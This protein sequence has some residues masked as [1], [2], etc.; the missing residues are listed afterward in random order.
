MHHYGRKNSKQLWRKEDKGS[1]HWVCVSPYDHVH[2]L[3]PPPPL[4]DTYKFYHH[5]LPDDGVLTL[6]ELHG[7]VRDIWLA[8]FDDQLEAEQTSRR[9]GRP[10]SATQM[11]M[12]EIKLRDTDEYR[13]G[14][15]AYFAP[16]VVLS[17][18]ISPR[19]H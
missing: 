3:T 8:R 7:I 4:V 11:K 12:E 13:T 10:K 2:Y 6:E 1:F 18:M 5:C 9:K 19:G 17:W 14:L 16:I 15:G